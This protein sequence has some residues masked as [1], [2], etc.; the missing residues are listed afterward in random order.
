MDS[1]NIPSANAHLNQTVDNITVQTLTPTPAAQG[2]FI[3]VT[4]AMAY[5]TFDNTAPSATNGLA[6]PSGTAP[7][8]F[9]FAGKKIKVLS[10]AASS[11]VNVLWVF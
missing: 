11:I 2:C 1:Y 5:M 7:I 8:F 4:T 9:P 10:S 6:V 3:T